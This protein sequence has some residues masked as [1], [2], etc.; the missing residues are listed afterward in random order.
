[1]RQTEPIKNGRLD[2]KLNALLNGE[3]T[4]CGV[5]SWLTREASNGQNSSM[6]TLDKPRLN[7]PKQDRSQRLHHVLSALRHRLRLALLCTAMAFL[8]ACSAL[9]TGYEQGEHLAYWWLDR[10]V[11]VSSAQAPEV[12]EAIARFFRWHRREQLPA[13]ATLLT[14]AKADIQQPLSAQRLRHY[15]REA[16]RL[17][18]LAI[19]QTFPDV[20]TLLVTL[21]PEQLAQMEKRITEDN[22]KY[23]R[24]YLQGDEDGRIKERIDARMKRVMRYAELLY[25]NFTREQGR[26]IRTAI[27][28]LVQSTPA[29]L[30]LRERRQQAWLTLVR[31]VATERPP[32][33][34]VVRRL[35]RHQ[36]TWRESSQAN[37]SEIG[38]AVAMEIANLTTAAQREHAAARLQG[39]IEDTQALMRRP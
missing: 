29:R 6:A 39:W 23:R 21:S 1:M 7:A 16:Q 8:G 15:Q 12:R 13:I 18:H 9:K 22:A 24:T 31:E 17:G 28:P 2:G 10:Y 4:R 33:A 11:D 25:G 30:A 20:A 27:L 38:I 35:E 32:Q 26:Q 14:Q 5:Q 36:N 19:R 37:D 3:N 34:E